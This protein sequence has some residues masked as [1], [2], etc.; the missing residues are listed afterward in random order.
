MR[1][2]IVHVHPEPRSFNAALT[3]AAVVALQSAGHEVEVSDLYAQ[4]FNPASSRA[5]FTTVKNAQY[6]VQMDEEQF[7]AERNGFAPE[8]DA[9]FRKVE[10]C[11]VLIWQF[12]LWWYAPPAMLKGWVDRV[13]AFGR[14]YA[15]GRRDAT[16]MLQG[17][18][19]MLSIT[20]GAEAESYA[21]NG[22]NG[23]LDALLRPVQRGILRYV[24][25]QVLAPH[26]VFAPDEMT[27]EQRAVALANWSRRVVGLGA[28]AALDLG[29]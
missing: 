20:T 4:H 18:R 13:F 12:P 6:F 8:L 21:A 25:F 19:A 9:E 27:T 15:P 14:A 5:N 28:E 16:G 10:R 24:G 22:R 29:A 11:E 7:A 3:R 26:V 17:R 23:D 2:L 1:H